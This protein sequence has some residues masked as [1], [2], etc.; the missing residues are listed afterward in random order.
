MLSD[1]P[2]AQGEQ[3]SVRKGA[4]SEVLE[5]Q[6]KMEDMQINFSQM[7]KDTLDQM[8]ARLAKRMAE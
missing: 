7:L 6:R 1:M 2:T 3:D 8:H 5:M 4:E